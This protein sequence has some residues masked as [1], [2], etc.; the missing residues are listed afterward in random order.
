ML[1]AER[2]PVEAL[3]ALAPLLSDEPDSRSVLELA[4]RAYFT[5]SQMGRAERTFARLV[6]LDP[7]DAYARFALGR[8]CER[9]S[10]LQEALGHYRVAVALNPRAE[11]QEGLARLEESL[12][13]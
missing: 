6:E 5:S 9:Q 2:K 3:A 13:S 1:V 8:V 12:G 4:G 7:T 10:R 11:Y